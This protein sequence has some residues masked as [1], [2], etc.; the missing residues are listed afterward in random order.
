MSLLYLSIGLAVG[1]G[2]GALLTRLVTIKRISQSVND[3]L[4]VERQQLNQQFERKL[5]DNEELVKTTIAQKRETLESGFATTRE[6]LDRQSAAIGKEQESLERRD[7]KM[8]KRETALAEREEAIDAKQVSFERRE[9]KQL[10]REES[11]DAKEQALSDRAAELEQQGQALHT[12]LE[13]VAGLS[14]EEAQEQLFARLDEQ[15]ADEQGRLIAKR[16]KEAEARAKEEA[17]EIVARAV[18]R[19][20]A[21]HTAEATISRVAIAEEEFKGRIIG[22]EG[23]NIRAFQE[24]TGVDVIIDDTPGQITISCFDGVRRE[25]A[26]RV[27]EELLADGRIH[28]ARIEEVLTK[29]QQDMDR[30]IVRY[31]E[32]AA[33]AC[34]VSGLHPT[35]DQDPWQ[36]AVPDVVRPKR[37]A[38]LNGSRLSD[39]RHGCRSGHGSQAGPALWPPA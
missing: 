1:A 24:A 13:E 32:E 7:A 28:P 11:L 17:T 9:N 22:K 4:D 5:A 21:E 33:F 16:T 37:L 19:Y 20:A 27:M 30:E 15:L 39:W 6:Q 36:T 2:A 8:A 38:A 10:Q 34:E 31:G 35:S 23:R 25:I 18:Q 14:A 12:K 26:R 3:Q 29:V